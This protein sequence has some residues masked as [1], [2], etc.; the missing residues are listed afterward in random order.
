MRE[1]REDT[2]PP[3]WDLTMPMIKTLTPHLVYVLPLS[4]VKVSIVLVVI[5]PTDQT[6]EISLERKA[7]LLE[8][9]SSS[10]WASHLGDGES[11]LASGGGEVANVESRGQH[12][13]DAHGPEGD[14][15]VVVGVGAVPVDGPGGWVSLKQCLPT[16]AKGK[17]EFKQSLVRPE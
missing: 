12:S 4:H 16:K 10:W 15:Q 7:V 13:Q 14:G 2:Q 9:S 6:S 3:S 11:T 8:T 5:S 17:L 1:R